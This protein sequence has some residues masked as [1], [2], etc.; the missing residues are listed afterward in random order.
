METTSNTFEMPTRYDATASETKWYRCWEEAGLFQ[1]DADPSKEA[2]CITIPPPNITGS[3]H[4]GH[5][6][7][8]PLQ[9]M[10][11][12]FQRLRGRSVLILPGQD[13]AGIATQSVVSKQL[14]EQGVHPAELGREGFNEKVWEWR[15]KSGSMILEGFRALGCAFDWSRSRFTLDEDYANSVLEVFID[16]FER[17]LIFRGKRVVNWD[18]SLKTNVS[19]IETERKITK[20]HLF[21]VRYPFAD[22]SGH[23]VIATTRPETMLADVAVAVHPSDARYYGKVGKEIRLPLVNRLIPLVADIYPDPEFGTGAVKITP[24]HDANDYGVGVRHGLSM[25]VIFDESAKVTLADIA[26]DEL[27]DF[28]RS[29]DGVDRNAAR[30]LIVAELEAQG[31]IE[32]IEDHEIAVVISDRSKEV[33][34]PLLSE[35]WFCD[36]PKLAAPVIEAVKA[37]EIKFTPARYERIFLAW[38]ENVHEWTLSR[39]LW[40]GHRIPI[41]YDA[42]EKPY[43]ALSWDDAQAK[44]GDVPIVRQDE[45][46]LDT[47]FSSG[48][49]PFATLGWP[50]ETAD[51]AR[52]YPTNTLI[53][54]RNIINLWVARM[55]MMG[56]D[57]MGA[58]PFTNVLIHATVLTK[59]GRRMSKS[60]GTGVDPMTVIDTL[61][62]DVL[63][64]TL[65]SQTG[66]NQDVRYSEEKNEEARNFGNKIWN[67]T[68]FILM[69]VDEPPL[70]PTKLNPVDEW[71]LA[72][73]ERAEK[74][75]EEAYAAFDVQLACQKLYR[76]FWNDLCDWYIEV[77]KA[78]LA[79]VTTREV[80]Q[81]VLL[82]AIE[83]FLT[84]L[85]PV[86]PHLTEELYSHLPLRTKVPLLMGSSWPQTSTGLFSPEAEASVER[87][88]EIVRAARALRATINLPAIRR[89][90]VLYVEGD[91]T[92][93]VDIIM[94]QAWF[95]EIRFGKPTE[96]HITATVAGVD[97]H[98]PVEGLVDNEKEMAR[99][100]RELAKAREDAAK[101]TAR[102]GNPQFTEKA[103]PEVIQ[104]DQAALLDLSEK[105]L[106]LEERRR[107]FE[108]NA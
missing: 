35:Q 64:W 41:Y 12:R 78:R 101:L 96:A 87:T 80:P 70:P 36:Q 66:D 51:L 22:G 75:I 65:L 105:I 14:R 3:L 63:R 83:S 58:K 30:K 61:G 97:L 89:V 91:L 95:E 20:G 76:F 44:A 104:R 99:L 11:G 86:M 37:G 50:N 74:E 93:G 107:T 18:P 34:E 85:H 9:D 82:T 98:L 57:R 23:V 39:Q 1:P 68:R 27:S 16:W 33:I 21:H 59:D 47:W 90:P 49:W 79:D 19:D 55:L 48:L 42:N 52:Y 26:H 72:R 81:W 102:L 31:F 60:L 32:K 88:F 6:L 56:F 8:Y 62:A 71:L 100:D 5:A 103:K 2:F 29:L 69:N 45:D 108:E 54:D 25:P 67:A 46:V 7:C 10:I 38:M 84:M 73:L 106:R 43:A 24:A 92:H 13:H 17:G 77:S 53:T 15:E 4:M 40:W 28:V 94:S